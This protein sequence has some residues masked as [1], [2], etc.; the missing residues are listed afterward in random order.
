MRLLVTGCRGQLGQ[1][2]AEQARAL[3]HE[4]HGFDL[5]ELDITCAESVRGAATRVRPDAIVN[6]AAFTA[7]DLAESQADQAFWVNGVAV[8]HLAGAANS[9]GASLVQVSTDYV[10]D[11]SGS[12]PWR[13]DDP[14]RPM[15]SYGRSKLAGELAATLAERHLIARTAWLFGVGG[16]N[17]VEAI[18]RQLENG[19]RALRVVAD[20]HGCPTFAC[21]LALVLLRLLERGARGVFHAV[22]DGATTWHGFAEEI[23]RQLGVQATVAPQTTAEAGRPAARPAFGVLDT[24]RLRS[25]LG[26]ALPSWPDALRRYLAMTANRR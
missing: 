17:F 22:N 8:A 16:N 14:V 21:D 10:F 4:Y 7:V 1:A 3:G 11:G 19:N 24:S 25:V 5:P 2:L 6:C 20:Q 9:V 15:S 12:R 13:E 23:V 26:N 18:R